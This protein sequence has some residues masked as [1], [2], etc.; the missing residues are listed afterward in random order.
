MLLWMIRVVSFNGI[1][2]SSLT[3]QYEF[4]M[5]TG[6]CMHFG[7]A[8]WE[9]CVITMAEAHLVSILSH[10]SNPPVDQLAK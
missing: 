1:L 10:A 7:K 9:L 4:F 2:K 6:L 3:P 8:S 5:I